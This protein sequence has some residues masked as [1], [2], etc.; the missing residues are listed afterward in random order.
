VGFK[1]WVLGEGGVEHGGARQHT[2]A[3]A[4]TTY[5]GLIGAGEHDETEMKH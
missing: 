3:V 5:C 1:E 4:S 2:H